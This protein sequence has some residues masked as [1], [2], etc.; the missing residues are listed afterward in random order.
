MAL[1]SVSVIC[2]VWVLKLHN[3]G[4]YHIKVPAWMKFIVFKC[5]ARVLRCHCSRD[6]NRDWSNRQSKKYAKRLAT[7]E[8]S[9]IC[10]RLMNGTDRAYSAN[11]PSENS[12]TKDVKYAT[13]RERNHVDSSVESELHKRHHVTRSSTNHINESNSFR[14]K[15][16]INSVSAVIHPKLPNTPMGSQHISPSP[17]QARDTHSF[18]LERLA[19]MDD[20]LQ[21]LKVF[22]AK[23]ERDDMYD[24]MIT[25]W[26]QVAQVMDR[27]FFWLFLVITVVATLL[28]LVMT[29]MM[30]YH[31]G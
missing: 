31:Y 29:P 20:I 16:R 8:G 28:I 26:R 24:D 3:N 21:H 13:S 1:T 25:E 15:S 7:R 27:F 30:R 19:I 9:D 18:E 5:L 4:P 10:L 23:R 17:A 14:Q 22:A 6:T 12:P 11:P 2:T